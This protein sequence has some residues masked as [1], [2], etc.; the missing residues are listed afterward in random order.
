MH[1]HNEVFH[2]TFLYRRTYWLERPNYHLAEHG[3]PV[4]YIEHHVLPC[5]QRMYRVLGFKLFLP[6]LEETSFGSALSYL[7]RF[8]DLKIIHLLRENMLDRVI[9]KLLAER[10]QQFVLEEGAANAAVRPLFIEYDRCVD[11][12]RRWEQILARTI[13]AFPGHPRYTLTYKKLTTHP[14]MSLAGLQTWLGVEPIALER[15][16][17]LTKQRVKP[18][19]EMIENY[20]ELRK[21]TALEHPSWLR[22][23]DD[24]PD[25][26]PS[27][28]SATLESCASS[29]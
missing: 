22:Y 1:F 15:T 11:M 17:K 26:L 8:P 24:D 29:R 18:K 27:V 14:S 4:R 7:E 2:Q 9:S 5:N 10:D 20:E 16:L 25:A 23:F 13:A 3:D 19:R 21:K 28:G 12:L 6:Q